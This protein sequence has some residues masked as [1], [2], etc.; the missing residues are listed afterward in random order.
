MNNFSQELLFLILIGVFANAND[1]DLSN[2]TTILLLLALILFN[3][4]SNGC[5]CNNNCGYNNNC[6][7]NN[8][9]CCRNQCNLFGI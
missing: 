5:G 8:N 2:N 4:Q 3:G 9:C 1:V 6:G 7:C